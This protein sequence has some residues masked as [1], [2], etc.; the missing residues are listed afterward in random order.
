[1][2]WRRRRREWAAPPL[3]EPL[4]DQIRDP[5]ALPDQRFDA[6]DSLERAVGHDTVGVALLIRRYFDRVSGK[7]LAA[8]VGL[9]PGAL[10]MRLM[11]TRAAARARDQKI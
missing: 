8:E 11:R 9:T 1:M 7:D 4:I 5:L 6:R 10:R 2:E 3:D